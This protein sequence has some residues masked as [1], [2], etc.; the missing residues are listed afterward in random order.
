MENVA[1]QGRTVLFVSHNMGAV[2]DLCET[3]ILL[4]SGVITCRGSVGEV[5]DVYSRLSRKKVES[6][7]A[8]DNSPLRITSMRVVDTNG[9]QIEFDQAFSVEVSCRVTAPV[10]FA[11]INFVL[12][13]ARDIKIVHLQTNTD[14]IGLGK[15]EPGDYMFFV[16]LP[17]L[18]LV[19]GTYTAIT[20]F[21]VIGSKKHDGKVES[22]YLPI[23]VRGNLARFK[24]VLNPRFGIDWQV[25]QERVR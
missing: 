4:D 23:H 7:I 20:K 24:N 12:L 8:E 9:E 2:T 18:W 17:T 21:H 3:A 22:P 15:I 13:D 11:R 14:E 25:L 10:P 5:V 19:S 6:Q 1:Q 16:N